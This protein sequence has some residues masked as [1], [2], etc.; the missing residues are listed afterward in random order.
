MMQQY[1]KSS[2]LGTT[3]L[4]KKHLRFEGPPLV[5]TDVTPERIIVLTAVLTP[6]LT[7]STYS[8]NKEMEA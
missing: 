2:R 1:Q 3:F 5:R 7:S 6:H 4:L 8:P